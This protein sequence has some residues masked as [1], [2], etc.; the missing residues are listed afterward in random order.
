MVQTR[1]A[2]PK[3][4]GHYRTIISNSKDFEKYLAGLGNLIIGIELLLTFQ[5]ELGDRQAI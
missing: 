5:P 1:R 2:D 3:L 4:M